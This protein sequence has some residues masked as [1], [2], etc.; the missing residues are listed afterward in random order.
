M[1]D[2]KWILRSSSADAHISSDQQLASK[3]GINYCTLRSRFSNPGTLRLFELRALNDVL[4]FK[5]ED[6][7]KIVKGD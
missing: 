6:I 2:F 5:D 1:E 7:L 4:H 3:V